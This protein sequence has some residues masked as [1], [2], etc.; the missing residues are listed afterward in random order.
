MQD[1]LNAHLTSRVLLILLHTTDLNSLAFV[2]NRF[3]EMFQ[4]N[5]IERREY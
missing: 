3:H 2:V 5:S 1:A 4:S